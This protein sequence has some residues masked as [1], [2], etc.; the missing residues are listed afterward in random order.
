VD[1]DQLKKKVEGAGFFVAKFEASVNFDHLNVS[2][3]AHVELFGKMFHF[4]NVG[5]QQ[6]NN[7]VNIRIIDKGFV[8]SKEF[9]KNARYT[10]MECYQTGVMGS[11]CKKNGKAEG[12]RIYHVTI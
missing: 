2:N 6:L 7:A 12:V 4:L 3:D 1:F 9:K 5:N 8:T 11:C 10:Q